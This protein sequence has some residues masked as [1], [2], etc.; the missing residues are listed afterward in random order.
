MKTESGVY[1]II[2]TISSLKAAFPLTPALS[3]GEREKHSQF[4][5]ISE[6]LGCSTDPQRFSLSPRER[7]GAFTLLEVIVVIIILA[8]VALVFLP[9]FHVPRTPA[10]RISCVNQ[11]KQVGLAFKSWAIDHTDQFPMQIS[12]NAGGTREL[13]NGPSVS[14]HFRVISNELSTPK[15]LVCPADLKRSSAT[16]FSALQNINISY[17]VGVDALTTNEQMLLSGDRNITN[18]TRVK[19][20]ML[21]LTTNQ[22]VGWTADLHMLQGNIGLADGRVQQVTSSRLRGAIASTGVTTNRLAMP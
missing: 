5:I 16:G 8:I 15:L 13:A 1:L 11:V 7:A 12:T 22:P 14:V 21:E 19:N 10:R 6:A 4:S 20:G 17:F 18:G 3:L 2:T 9:A